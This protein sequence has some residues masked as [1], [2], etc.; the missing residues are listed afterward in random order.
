MQCGL[1]GGTLG[2]KGW[3]QLQGRRTRAEGQGGTEGKGKGRGRRGSEVG[4]GQG[5]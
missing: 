5:G 4:A 2:G 1:V 3:G